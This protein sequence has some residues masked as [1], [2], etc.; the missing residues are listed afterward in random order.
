MGQE[1]LPSSFPGF[2]KLCLNGV[3]GGGFWLDSAHSPGSAMTR[4]SASFLLCRR[5]SRISF[6]DGDSGCHRGGKVSPENASKISSDL[7]QAL[8]TLGNSLQYL[9]C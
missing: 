5:K 8:L 3:E 6:P 9:G 7:C 4:E 1:T 2:L